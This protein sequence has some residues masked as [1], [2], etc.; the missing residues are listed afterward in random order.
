MQHCGERVQRDLVR[1]TNADSFAQLL[2]GGIA[3][4]P[5]LAGCPIEVPWAGLRPLCTV[6][7]L[8]IIGPDPRFEGLY[9]ATGHFTMG[10]I[11]APA[12][13]EAVA[14]WLAGTP[15]ALDLA[16]FSPARLV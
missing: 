3:V 9:H 4:V 16:P 7:Q 15:C 2:N 5:A 11:S 10:I 8:P 14:H 12:T 1:R 13:A 6:D